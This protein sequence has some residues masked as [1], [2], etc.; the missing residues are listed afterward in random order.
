MALLIDTPEEV[1]EDHFLLRIVMKNSSFR[2][3][4]FINIKTSDGTDPLL[5]RP[6]S[7]FDA[8]GDTAKVII[9]VIGRG[10]ELLSRMKAG[11]INI[12]GPSGNGFTIERDKNVLLVGGGVGNAP[13]YYLMKELK[14]KGNRV[15]YIYCS[16]SRDYIFEKNKYRTLADEFILTTDDGSD[17]VKGFATEVMADKISA[18]G[19]D[20]IY[21][22]GPNPMMEKIVRLAEAGTPVE[23]SVENY[24]GCGAGL[25]VGCTVDTVTGYKRACVDGPVFD[26]RTILWDKIPD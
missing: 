8:D 18:A 11:D 9:R 23:V 26:G 1:A 16:R 12:I 4:Q 13:L 21:T 20:R 17:G 25:C 7:I 10:T 19:Y 14:E 5:R 15:T 24:F 2:P 22:C 6:F 3:G